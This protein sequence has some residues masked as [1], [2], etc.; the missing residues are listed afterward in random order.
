MIGYYYLYK[1]PSKSLFTYYSQSILFTNNNDS[2]Y[3]GLIPSKSNLYSN[4]AYEI[5]AGT[6][7]NALGTSAFEM[8]YKEGILKKRK[9]SLYMSLYHNCPE[10]LYIKEVSK[11]KTWQE[12]L[13][14]L[15]AVKHR[16][17]CLEY[18]YIEYLGK[19]HYV[20]DIESDFDFQVYL[21]SNLKILPKEVDWVKALDVFK[22]IYPKPLWYKVEL[23]NYRRLS[24]EYN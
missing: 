15:L 23:L 17:V 16:K 20:L 11:P 13:A 4:V 14:V 5:P 7:Y 24:H 2:K 22:N 3:E 1:G 19:R 18:S 9:N 6:I 21:L 10:N 8:Y 12:R